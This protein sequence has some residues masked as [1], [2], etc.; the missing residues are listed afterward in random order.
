MASTIYCC[1][2]LLLRRMYRDAAKSPT[3]IAAK[4]EGRTKIPARSPDRLPSAPIAH[5]TKTAPRTPAAAISEKSDVEPMLMWSEAMASRVG[6]KQ[7][8][9]R[10]PSAKSTQAV[11][12]VDTK[13]NPSITMPQSTAETTI[14]LNGLIL[15]TSAPVP[16]RPT[17]IKLP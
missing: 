11:V 16:N 5:G 13:Y 15:V 9:K 2:E 7:A 10:P 6:Q 12:R 3:P 4:S 14:S 17:A 8:M 1:G